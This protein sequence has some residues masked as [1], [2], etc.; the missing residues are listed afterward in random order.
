[1]PNVFL[2]TVVGSEIDPS[3]LA[4]CS[5]KTSKKNV[6]GSVLDLSMVAR[7][8]PSVAMLNPIPMDPSP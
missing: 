2:I 6:V 7:P 5:K 3:F 1:M 4:L 8:L